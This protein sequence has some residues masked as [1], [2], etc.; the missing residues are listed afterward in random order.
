MPK[1]QGRFWEG[2]A[3]GSS[4]TAKNKSNSATLQAA[5]GSR[6]RDQSGTGD[7]NN[8]L[9][10]CD[11]E[12]DSEKDSGYSETGSE[13]VHTDLNDEHNGVRAAP[14]EK[15]EG[16][17]ND[18]NVAIA[19]GRNMA[20]YEEFSPIYIIKNLVVKPCPAPDSSSTRHRR[21]RNT[22]EILNQ[23]GLL[24]IALRTKELLEQ[25]AATDREIAQLHQHT[26]LCARWSRAARK[27]VTKALTAWTSSYRPWPSPA[28]TPSWI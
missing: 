1:E 15:R 14:R 26:H 20:P 24:A 17:N 25:N 8:H 23:S 28:A 22:A 10:L 7:M 19:T 21:F 3:R 12:K 27:K 4:K 6:H 9:V 11:G 18:N 13:S 5:L 16:F 2:A